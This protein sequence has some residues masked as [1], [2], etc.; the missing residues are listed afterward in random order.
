MSSFQNT[1]IVD[2]EPINSFV[3][4]VFI[5]KLGHKSIKCEN[6]LEALQM[7]KDHPNIDLVLLDLNMPIKDGYEF[8]SDVENDSF[9]A[10]RN[11]RIVIISAL[12][13]IEFEAQI[14]QRNI[15]ANR[16]IGFIEKPIQFDLIEALYN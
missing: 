10:N 6:G 9:W 11:F 1:L 15:A 13:K 5:E 7:L 8:L 14:N 2:D 3:I 16:V 4:Q 12:S